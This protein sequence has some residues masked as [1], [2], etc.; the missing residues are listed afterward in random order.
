M[1]RVRME[2]DVHQ[3]LQTKTCGETKMPVIKTKTGP[4]T[5]I[6]FIFR[7]CDKKLL[8]CGFFS[9]GYYRIGDYEPAHNS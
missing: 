1:M 9:E 6:T 3:Q 5:I 8:K 7:I 2:Y 4:Y